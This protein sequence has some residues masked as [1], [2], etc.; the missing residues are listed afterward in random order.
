MILPWPLIREGEVRVRAD[1]KAS[2]PVTD[3]GKR[4]LE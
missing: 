1:S 3:D 4:E 2:R